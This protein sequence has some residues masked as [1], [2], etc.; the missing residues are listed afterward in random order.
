MDLYLP[1][2]V[3]GGAN[4]WQALHC[5]TEWGRKWMQRLVVALDA[6]KQISNE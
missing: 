5:Q 6:S 3:I 4:V 1:T 2:E